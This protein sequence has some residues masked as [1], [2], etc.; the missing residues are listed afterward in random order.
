[1]RGSRADLAAHSDL[2]HATSACAG[3]RARARSRRP[4][5]W[6]PL[7]CHPSVP[8]LAIARVGCAPKR[9]WAPLS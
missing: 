8:D 5:T 4:A 9:G 3:A 7:L 1:M 2:V 6:R